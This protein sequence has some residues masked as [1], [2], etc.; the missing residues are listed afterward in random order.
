MKNNFSIKFKLFDVFIMIFSLLLI[1]VVIVSTNIAFS[2]TLDKERIVQ[3]Y[4]QG[5]LLENKQIEIDDLLEEKHVILLKDD[6][7]GLLGDMDIV[8]NKDKGVCIYDVTCPNYYCKNQGWVNSVGYPVV[9]IP[10]GVY[11]I[12]TSSTIDQDTILG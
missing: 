8:I 2:N 4:Y 6:Y 3:I 1:G 5:Q 7:D 10:N 11:V 12:I 9:C